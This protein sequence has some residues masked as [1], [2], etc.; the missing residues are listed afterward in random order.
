MVAFLISLMF[1]GNS[2][3]TW[4]L[5]RMAGFWAYDSSIFTLC[6]S[7]LF[8]H[9]VVARSSSQNKFVNWLAQ[10]AFPLYLFSDFV[11][12]CLRQY[13]VSYKESLACWLVM[14]LFLF[15]AIV[16]TICYEYA[17]RFTLGKLEIPLVNV[18]K[19]IKSNIYECVEKNKFVSL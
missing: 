13:I 5:E 8:F 4:L 9:S 14:P 19:K 18:L 1:L 10:F 6:L 16:A 7:I 15:T 2:I 11:W 3:F 17:R 12:L